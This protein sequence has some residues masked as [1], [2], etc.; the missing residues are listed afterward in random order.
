[1]N[2]I[3]ES[4]WNE[5]LINEWA[6][7]VTDEE[8]ELMEKAEELRKEAYALLNE[9]QRNAVEAYVDCMLERG[10]ITT[11]RAFMTGCKFTVSFLSEA[12]GTQ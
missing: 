10:D 9:E 11:E 7:Q 5:Y 1:M 3:L 2:P 4:L 6:E 12:K 8:K